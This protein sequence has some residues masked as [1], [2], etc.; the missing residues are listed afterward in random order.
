MLSEK[1]SLQSQYN[2]LKNDHKNCDQD[3]LNLKRT[4]YQMNNY[5]T[6]LGAAQKKIQQLEKELSS[7]DNSH[8]CRSEQSFAEKESKIRDL[9][10][11]LENLNNERDDLRQSQQNDRKS[12][13][14]STHDSMRLFSMPMNDITMAFDA[15]I[16]TDPTNE[17]CSCTDMAAQITALKRDLL[18]KESQF[19]TYKMEMEIHPW[20]QEKLTMEKRLHEAD[21]KNCT[22]RKELNRLTNEMQQTFPIPSVCSRCCTKKVK[23]FSNQMTQTQTEINMNAP[24]GSGIVYETDKMRLKTELNLVQ[25]KYRQLKELL[26]MRSEKIQTLENEIETL[27]LKSSN[28]NVNVSGFFFSFRN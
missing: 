26:H 27:K 20:H 21:Q 23:T 4:N 28:G 10:K 9:E 24:M 7:I 2:T 19:Y 16:Q 14:Q 13:R 8:K 18:I 22:L 5:Q 15:N 3:I 1:T 17:L 6:E 11:K 12:R 25:K